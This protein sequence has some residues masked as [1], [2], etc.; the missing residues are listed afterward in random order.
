M[1]EFETKFFGSDA[2]SDKGSDNKGS[3]KSNRIKELFKNK[4]F[5][6]ACIGAGV[7][8]LIVWYRN[9]QNAVEEEQDPQNMLVADGYG[10]LEVSG[11][12]SIYDYDSMSD[13]FMNQ[14]NGV[15]E[16]FKTTID[17][18]SAQLITLTDRLNTNSNVIK[19]QA[20]AIQMQNDIDAMKSNSDAWHYATSD[21]EKQAL[22]DANKQIASNYGW[23]FNDGDGYWYDSN[24]KK[25]YSTVTQISNTV[26]VVGGKDASTK[27]DDIAKMMDNS[28]AWHVSNDTDRRALEAENYAIASKYGFTYNDSTGLWY[29]NGTPVYQTETQKAKASSGSSSSSSSSSSNSTGSPQTVINLVADTASFVSTGQSI[30]QKIIMVLCILLMLVLA[31]V[32]FVKAFNIKIKI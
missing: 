19:E 15:T 12:G 18:M 6:I 24:G 32:F 8:G 31:T 13:S 20:Y 5:V 26:S 11:G 14:L 30:L 27:A 23:T 22:A 1:P 16:S 17:D 9:S 29:D 25:V 3:K 21:A 28:D 10:A 4:P 2:G 7:L